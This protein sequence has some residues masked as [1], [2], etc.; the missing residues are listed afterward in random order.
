[1]LSSCVVPYKNYSF[2]NLFFFLWVFEIWTQN[3]QLKCVLHC[4]GPHLGLAT[5]PF[6]SDHAWPV[7]AAPHSTGPGLAEGETAAQRLQ[8]HFQRAVCPKF[9][10]T[11]TGA[12]ARRRMDKSVGNHLEFLQ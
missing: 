11:D 7:A 9:W 1:M 10:Y 5:C 6:F 3:T 2:Y 12:G 4:G 8:F